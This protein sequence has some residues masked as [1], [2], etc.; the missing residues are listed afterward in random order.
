MF[1]NEN[2]NVVLGWSEKKR[3]LSFYFEEKQK[4]EK[5]A[6]HRRKWGMTNKAKVKVQG[7]KSGVW[8]SK[9]VV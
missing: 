5:L 4:V 3:I 1:V 2:L 9:F 6:F 7:L 8:G